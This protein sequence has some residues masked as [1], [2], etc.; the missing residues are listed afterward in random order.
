MHCLDLSL[1]V[2][3]FLQDAIERGWFREN[4]SLSGEPDMLA[5]ITTAQ[6]VVSALAYMHERDLIH[7]DVRG[8]NIMLCSSTAS[9][10][11]F[12][13]QVRFPLKFKLSPGVLCW[14][15][16]AAQQLEQRL[17][18]SVRSRQFT[19]IESACRLVMHA[20]LLC[21]ACCAQRCATLFHAVL[22]YAMRS[23]MQFCK[24]AV[25]TLPNSAC[26]AHL[27]IKYHI[28]RF[29]KCRCCR[30]AVPKS[31]AVCDQQTL[32]TCLA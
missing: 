22:C 31:A 4:M 28:S 17:L 32:L 27:C 14:A 16:C 9:P 10:R 15:C 21:W 3:P 23:P 18:H 13:A 2:L 20:G 11:G 6:E 26:I 7:G 8:G 12:T 25:D 19:K 5:I 30:P 29:S 1:A 24:Y